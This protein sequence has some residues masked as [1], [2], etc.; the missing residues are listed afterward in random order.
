MRGNLKRGTSSLTVSNIVN[1]SCNRSRLA[2]KL[3]STALS[4]S[5][6]STPCLSKLN[7]NRIA[8]ERT[9][10]EVVSLHDSKEALAKPRGTRRLGFHLHIFRQRSLIQALIHYDGINLAKIA[11]QAMH[12]TISG[13]NAQG[14][15]IEEHCAS[16]GAR[17]GHNF[18]LRATMKVREDLTAIKSYLRRKYESGKQDSEQP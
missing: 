18:I 4:M 1:G 8:R 6:R 2:R 3:S 14:L 5:W 11:N 15:V 16:M 9:K 12:K 17:N 13:L 10:G 7:Y